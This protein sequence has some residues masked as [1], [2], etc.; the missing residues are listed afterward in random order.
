MAI[1]TTQR[2][3]SY[4]TVYGV[5]GVRQVIEDGVTVSMTTAMID[6]TNDEVELFWVPAGAVI[7]GIT[8]S[9][10]DMD[11]SGSPTLA[12]DIGDDS[13]EDRLMAAST[14]G[15]TGT[16]SQTLARTGHMY[17]YS[18]ATKIKAYVQAAA[19]TGAAGTLSVSIRY[20]VDPTFSATNAV[21]A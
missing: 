11:T 8:V 13:D 9:A 10:S 12:F 6:N 14:V 4:G 1:Y 20:F 15:Q 5:G 16:I 2:S 21:V 19:A 3:Q 17:K 18:S 7:T